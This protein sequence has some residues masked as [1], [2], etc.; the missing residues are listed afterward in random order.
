MQADLD[1]NATGRTTPGADSPALAGAGE[2]RV[3]EEVAHLRTM[4]TQQ[5]ALIAQLTEVTRLALAAFRKPAVDLST[6]VGIRVL[7]PMMPPG[8]RSFESI[9]R[10]A[11]SGKIPARKEGRLWAF[12]PV[13]VMAALS[14]KQQAG[15]VAA[16]LANYKKERASRRGRKVSASAEKK[17]A[18]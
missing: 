3:L 9:R 16:F 18:A 13:D 17:H 10:Y 15:G 6:E 1:P 5:G 8:K 2:G 4:I 7:R 11:K 14:T 12:E